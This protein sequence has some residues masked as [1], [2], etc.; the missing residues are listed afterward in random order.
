M[1]ALNP[2]DLQDYEDRLAALGEHA[3]DATAADAILTRID[4]LLPRSRLTTTEYA[5]N[6]R[7][8]IGP[9]GDPVKWTP[10]KT[11][12]IP[13]IQD[14]CDLPM[15]K[16]VAV[17]GNARSAKT[18]GFENRVMKMWTYGPVTNLL[19]LMQSKEALEDYID[20]RG[21]WMLANHPEVAEKI[22]WTE[23][24]NSR[25]R[26][27]IGRS[28]ALWR[29]AVLKLLIAKAA[30]LIVAD[31]IDAYDK[32]VR[33]ALVTLI[34]NRQREYGSGSLA[35]IA[36]HPDAGPEEGV[37]QILRDSLLHCWWVPCPCCGRRSSFAEE[38][39]IRMRWN[40]PALLEAAESMDRTELLAKIEAE[41]ALVCPYEDCQYE[42]QTDEERLAM[43]AQGCWA[44]PH[45]TFDELGN[46]KGEPRVSRTM[47]FVIHAFMTPFVKLGEIAAEW[48]AAKLHFDD[49]GDDTNLKE[50]TCKTLG[51]TYRGSSA[52]EQIDEWQDVK[53]RLVAPYQRRTVPS[54]V[55]FLTA[56]V[57]VQGGRFEVRV[58]GWDLQ[59]RSWLIDAYAIK[60]WPGFT[61]IDP[62][63][64]LADWDIIEHAV[65]TQVFPLAENEYRLKN[66]EPELFMPIAKTVIDTGGEPGVYA[67]AI[68]WMSKLMSRPLRG[69]TPII[70][71][72]RVGLVAGSSKKDGELYGRL[73]QVLVDEHGKKLEPP[74]Y[75]RAPIVH[76]VKKIIANRMKT[77]DGPGRMHL[78]MNLPDTY[79]RELVAE[80]MVNGD[81]MKRYIRNETWDG[82]VM[83]EVARASLQ[84][85]RPG[86]WDQTPVWALPAERGK[87]I[88][89]QDRNR[90][91]FY[92]RLA[93]INSGQ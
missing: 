69:E 48:A 23:R 77:E 68:Q 71:Q 44:Q 88:D 8:V 86:M 64:R 56:F 65:I 67:N 10:A 16:V 92:D 43:S 11:P 2:L 81:W 39:A 46:I 34:R 60:Q 31:E 63:N 83:C 50:A 84:P 78:P 6:K 82:W 40:V 74:V 5:T 14:A 22:N 18:T 85:D 4:N 27:R 15:V 38:A 13:G 91:S 17:K 53:A 54:G 70:E 26:K 62:A 72:Y 59:N 90:V 35:M 51:E 79:V 80:R 57:D 42:I 21:E 73:R 37:D 55:K 49:T 7:Y 3:H 33:R 36:S 1:R 28:L 52:A 41:A 24:R 25:F 58:I 20:E 93:Q 29:T 12:Y 66:G 76:N 30:P 32:R 61:N 89:D 87:G 19:W 9:T 47:G 45:Q 75:I